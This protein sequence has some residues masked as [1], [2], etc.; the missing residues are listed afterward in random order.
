M[1]EQS[2]ERIKYYTE[3]LRA[4]LIIVLADLSGVISLMSKNDR[5]SV[6]SVFLIFGIF[7]TFALIIGII[8][9]CSFIIRYIKKI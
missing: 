5:N 1:N 6:E 4:L 3:W 2:K 8:I 9:A 7:G